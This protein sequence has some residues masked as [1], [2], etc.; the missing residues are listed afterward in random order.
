[1]SAD[2]TT[3]DYCA[4]VRIP[5]YRIEKDP[6]AWDDAKRELIHLLAEKPKLFDQYTKRDKAKS[7]LQWEAQIG[8]D[9]IVRRVV[10]DMRG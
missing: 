3:Q 2:N 1:M 5:G 8:I 9:E 4:S 6:H 7:L 10:R